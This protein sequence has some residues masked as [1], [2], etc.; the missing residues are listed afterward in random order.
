MANVR[1]TFYMCGF[2][3]QTYIVLQEAVSG[4]GLHSGGNQDVKK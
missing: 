1:R 2:R 3:M 4:M